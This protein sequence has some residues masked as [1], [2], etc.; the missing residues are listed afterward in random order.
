MEGGRDDR[1]EGDGGSY[2]F[3]GVDPAEV[4]RVEFHGVSEGEECAED[5]RSACE[6]E[7]QI[8]EPTLLDERLLCE[9]SGAECQFSGAPAS[10]HSMIVCNSSSENWPG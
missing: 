8:W 2:P 4:Q 3:A 9:H 6:L 5:L 1:A 7:I 10:I